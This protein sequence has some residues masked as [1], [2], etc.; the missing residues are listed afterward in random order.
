MHQGTE[1]LQ[2]REFLERKIL[3]Q[4]VEGTRYRLLVFQGKGWGPKRQNELLS[5]SRNSHLHLGQCWLLSAV[6]DA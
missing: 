6:S 1:G 3:G 2:G 5:G 4:E